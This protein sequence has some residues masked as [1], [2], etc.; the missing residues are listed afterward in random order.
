M[1]PKTCPKPFV[2]LLKPKASHGASPARALQPA[3][4]Q[5]HKTQLLPDQNL[6][7]RALPHKHCLDVQKNA[8]ALPRSATP[9]PLLT[10]RAKSGEVMSSCCE[11]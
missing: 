6:S 3:A 8:T 4:L 1:R 9:Q 7:Q 11:S 5:L 2:H 10:V